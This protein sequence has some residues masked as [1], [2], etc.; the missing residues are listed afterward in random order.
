[1]S[2]KPATATIDPAYQ[3]VC[4]D[5]ERCKTLNEAMGAFAMV[6][7][8]FLLVEGPVHNVLAPV[9]STLDDLI[10]SSVSGYSFRVS[11]SISSDRFVQETRQRPS[12]LVKLLPVFSLVAMVWFGINY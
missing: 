7:T 2:L 6:G 1:M 9:V 10:V 3:G 8:T 4:G 5:G 12:S 11:C